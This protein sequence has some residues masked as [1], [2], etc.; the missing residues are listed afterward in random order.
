MWPLQIEGPSDGL[1]FMPVNQFE[2]K[3]IVRIKTESVSQ[4]YI[5]ASFQKPK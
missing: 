5:V 1:F 3:G 2:Y 4:S